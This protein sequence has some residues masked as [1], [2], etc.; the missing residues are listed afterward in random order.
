MEID[1][2]VGEIIHT[3]EKLGIEK[4]TLLI[5]LSDNGPWLNYGNH[6]GSA[7]AFREGKI[8]TFEGGQRVPCIMKM[9][10]TLPAGTTCNEMI[11]NMDIMPTI[12]ELTNSQLPNNKIDGVSMLRL[13]KGETNESP[14][15]VFYYYFNGMQA[16]RYN[17]WKLVLP[18]EYPSY[19]T[20]PGADGYPGPYAMKKTGFSLYNLNRDKGERYDLKEYYPEMKEKMMMMVEEGRK[21]LG[22]E[23]LGIIGTGVRKIGKY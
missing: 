2:S 11:S 6:A 8:N 13:I 18:H 3:L 14:R 15:K 16:I 12:A 7:G 21:E 4:N 17:N 1:W 22:D 10:G 23:N 5:F 19:D 20:I 9:P